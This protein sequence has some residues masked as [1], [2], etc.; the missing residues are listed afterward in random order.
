MDVSRMPDVLALAE[1]V[2]RTKTPRILIK[3]DGEELV[4]V[5][6][7]PAKPRRGRGKRTS[8]SDPIWD[9]VG[10]GRSEAGPT[11]V[12]EH[13]DE[14]LAEWEVSHNRA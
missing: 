7:A 13:V 10:M 3:A 4:R 8:A 14:F 12:S 6:P 5:M 2:K 1:Q 9:V 11:N